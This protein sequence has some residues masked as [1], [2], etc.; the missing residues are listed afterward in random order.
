V[1]Y[2]DS[3]KAAKK[4]KSNDEPWL[5]SYADLVTNLMAFFIMLLSMSK[6][7]VVKMN[8][9][10]KEV[11]RVRYDSLDVLEKK[12]KESIFKSKIDRRVQVSLNDFGL[13]IEFRGEKMFDPGTDAIT[14]DF[15]KEVAPV[16]QILSKI[17]PKYSFSLEGHTDDVPLVGSRH[18]KDNWSLSSARGV[19]MMRELAAL[20]VPEKRMNIA[21]FAE[22]RPKEAVEPLLAAAAK[23][24]ADKKAIEDTIRLARAQ[25][26]RVVVRVYQ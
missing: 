17:E 12:L 5:I 4:P 1:S 6:F 18:F 7:D 26:R 8:A 3:I 23:P 11:S 14:P 22:T 19:S 10:T 25:N 16:L 2:F 24:G 9:V 20:G 15:R 13:N 21:G